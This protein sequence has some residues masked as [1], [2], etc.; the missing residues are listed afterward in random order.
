MFWKLRGAEE[1]KTKRA[2]NL[3]KTRYA[4][5]KAGHVSVNGYVQVRVNNKL[6]YAHRIIWQMHN[7][8]I[9]KDV[10]I[11]HVDTNRGNNSLSNLRLATSSNNK[12]NMNKTSHNKSGFKGVSLHKKTGR[13]AAYYKKFGRKI[14][15]GY[16]KTGIEA[17]NAYISAVTDAFGGYHRP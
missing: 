5:K 6:E 10:E 3:H 9:S 15:I 4:N 17:H 13:F 7:G 8:D 16:F 1:F 11:D 14:H 2:F 12:W